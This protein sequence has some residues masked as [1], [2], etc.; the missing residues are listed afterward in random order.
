MFHALYFFRFETSYR[1]YEV[2]HIEVLTL[3]LYLPLSRLHYGEKH[4]ASK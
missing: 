3:N 1:S 2:I 4:M